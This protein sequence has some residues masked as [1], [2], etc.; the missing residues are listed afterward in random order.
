M[1]GPLSND[2]RQRAIPLI[3]VVRER[4]CLL[5]VGLVIG[6]IEVEHNGGR[7]RSG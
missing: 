2:E 4:E 1:G 7:R 6:V 3:V 5:A